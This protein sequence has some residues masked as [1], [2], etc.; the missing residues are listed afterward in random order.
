MQERIRYKRY[1]DGKLSTMDPEALAHNEDEFW[2]IQKEYEYLEFYA[3]EHRLENTSIALRLAIG[4]HNGSYRK[5]TI[6]KEGQVYKLPYVIHCLWVAKMLADLNVPV[7]KDE[8]DVMLAAALCHDMIEDM[9]FQDGGRE[10]YTVYG[11]DKRVYD[12][13]KLVSKRYDFTD[14]QER[15]FFHNIESDKLAL[16]VKLSD[17]CHNVEDLYNRSAW[18]IHEYSGET[19]KFFI[20]MCEYGLEHYPDINTTLQIFHEKMINL[21][22]AAEALVDRYEQR[23]K[24]LRAEIEALKKENIELRREWSKLWETENG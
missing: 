12:I 5:S 8:E 19:R 17:R 9:D 20:P 23:E 24:E 14:E 1:I 22:Q 3:L 11:L 10:L 21:T 16:L 7:S 18:K 15:E 4:L 13:V 6:T 2:I